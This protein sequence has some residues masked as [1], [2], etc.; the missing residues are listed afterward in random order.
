MTAHVYISTPIQYSSL[1]PAVMED[2]HNP[3]HLHVEI[4]KVLQEGMFKGQQGQRNG[5]AKEDLCC[6]W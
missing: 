2:N 4:L 5:H 1:W 3:D 6:F